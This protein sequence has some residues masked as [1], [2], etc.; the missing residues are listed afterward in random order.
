[1][2]IC[3]DVDPSSAHLGLDSLSAHA[4]V[5][6]SSNAATNAAMSFIGGLLLTTGSPVM[7]YGE[8]RKFWTPWSGAS[9]EVQVRA[10]L[11]DATETTRCDQ[12]GTQ[13]R[14]PTVASKESK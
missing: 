4:A 14:V 2:L 7:T 13:G 5:G 10:H 8:A 6:T 12:S 1:M 11:G 9:H 3:L